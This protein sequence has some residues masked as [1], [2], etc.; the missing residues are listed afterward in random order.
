MSFKDALEKFKEKAPE[1]SNILHQLINQNSIQ[2]Q[3][4]IE[5]QSIFLNDCKDAINKEISKEDINNMIIQHILTKDIFDSIF[6]DQAFHKYNSIAKSIEDIINTFFTKE[7]EMELTKS[8]RGYYQTIINSANSISDHRQ[9][10]SFLK[11]V[12]QEFYKAYNP[13]KADRQGIEYTPVE[14]VGFM[15]KM[16]KYY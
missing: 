12:Y 1:I 16:N 13:S 15:I 8:I 9:K 2:N 6:D 5:K 7:K 3:A 14:I 10:Q 4:F 11:T